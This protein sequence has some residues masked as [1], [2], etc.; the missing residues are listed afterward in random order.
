[1]SLR[2]AIECITDY[3]NSWVHGER[4]VERKIGNTPGDRRMPTLSQTMRGELIAGR[5]KKV[6]NE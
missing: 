1:M 6:W 2:P 4:T 5:F 3:K